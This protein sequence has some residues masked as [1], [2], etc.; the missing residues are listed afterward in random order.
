MNILII[1]SFECSPQLSL[2]PFLIT[3]WP[4]P[5]K[6]ALT[7]EVA[8]IEPPLHRVRRHTRE[9]HV[10][11]VGVSPGAAPVAVAEFEAAAAGVG[12]EGADEGTQDGVKV[13]AEEAALVLGGFGGETH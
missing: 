13:V 1:T 4:A 10:P 9:E 12:L 11:R 3:A 7:Q 8:G 6:V 2:L 5:S